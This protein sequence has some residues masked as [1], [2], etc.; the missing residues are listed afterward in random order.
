M[1]PPCCAGTPPLRLRR[2]RG[3]EPAEKS[4][5]GKSAGKLRGDKPRH[6]ERANSGEGVRKSPR[7]RHGGIC[8][9]RRGG[10]PVSPSNVKA[11]R[12][13]HRFRAQADTAP[14]D[15]QQ[16]E[17]GDEFAEKLRTARA[18]VLRN[19]HDRL[20]KHQMGSG[21]AAE[22][23]CD[24]GGDIQRHTLPRH[25]ACQASAS[26]TAGLKCAPEIGPKV[27]IRVTRVAPVARVLARSAMA[28]PK[29][30]ATIRRESVIRRSNPAHSKRPALRRG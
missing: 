10:E 3:H 21:D 27:N 28:V 4:R 25:A 22:R 13:R 9:R 20:T 18:D 8:E 5:G 17:G 19:L 23:A 1:R 14:N 30:S 12:N 29:A 2:Q 26:V 11:D 16:A 15:G 7:E 24:L 6:I